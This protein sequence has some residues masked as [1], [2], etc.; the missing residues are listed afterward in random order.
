MGVE[1]V[2]LW[3]G[4]AK[5]NYDYVASRCGLF[6][7]AGLMIYGFGNSS[8][9]C[10]AAL[11]LNLPGRDEKV[12]EYK[13]YLQV[14]GRAGIPYTAC[15]HMANGIWST[16]PEP[17]RG[18]ASARGFDLEKA[19]HQTLTHGRRYTEDELWDNFTRFMCATWTLL[20]P[21]SSRPFPTEG[22][23]RYIA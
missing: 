21:T 1:C 8:V 23:W 3:T 10:Q 2:V 11:V 16:A 20:C 14:L 15:A 19:P 5:A 9:H 17:T 7:E 6:E 22:T 18:G 4:G 13:P 12:A